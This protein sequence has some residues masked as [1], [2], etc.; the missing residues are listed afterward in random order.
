MTRRSSL[1]VL[2]C[3]RSAPGR[4]FLSLA[5]QIQHDGR[6]EPVL[7]LGNPDLEPDLR[8][9]AKRGGVRV[10]PSANSAPVRSDS[11]GRQSSLAIRAFRKLTRTLL[12]KL[13]IDF[14]I[15]IR[16]FRNGNRLAHAFC[17]T[18][19]PSALII[20]D[21]RALG[22]DHGVCSYAYQAGISTFAAPFA[23]S[24]PQAD[25]ER[26]VGRRE[27][28]ASRGLLALLGGVILSRHPGAFR[29]Y[30]KYYLS[31]LTAGQLAAL[32]WL[33]EAYSAPWSFGG[34][35]T[36]FVLA[37]SDQD[38]ERFVAE[39]IKETKVLVTGQATLDPLYEARSRRPQERERLRRELNLKADQPLVIVAMPQHGEHGMAK[40]TDHLEACESLLRTL[41]G[42]E[43]EIL[44]SLHPRAN[45]DNY[46][47][48]M[49]RHGAHII[50][51]PLR[52]VIHA[53]D[54]FVASHS[55]TVR[56]AILLRIPTLILDDHGIGETVFAGVEGLRYVR[57][58]SELRGAVIRL[59]SDNEERSRVKI[60]L[61]EDARGID[62]FDGL[63]TRRVVDAV[64]TFAFSGKCPQTSRPDSSEA[65]AQPL[66]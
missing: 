66:R 62:P 61:K 30:G 43:A 60:Q 25:L 16:A 38:R 45:P 44:V 22:L 18:L 42:V 35:W 57:D 36:Q 8:S 40:W 14:L 63:S 55:S 56:W 13:I 11:R 51:V 31:F 24:D 41:S 29:Q 39:G 6:L 47:N 27:F 59:L 5:E 2:F 46:K 52:Q 1:V 21:D 19:S 15:T 20:A 58:R 23:I 17:S 10:W 53:A 7:V 48:M 3:S 37:F 32:S 9:L 28:D 26:R 33:G 4:E 12:P 64:M 65:T 49:K 50:P 54:V 34:G